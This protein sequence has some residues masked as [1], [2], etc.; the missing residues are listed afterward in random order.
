MHAPPQG[1]LGDGDEGQHLRLAQEAGVRQRS[2]GRCGRGIRRMGGGDRNAGHDRPLIGMQPAKVMTCSATTALGQETRQPPGNARLLDH[3]GRSV[4]AVDEEAFRRGPLPSAPFGVIRSPPRR[5]PAGRRAVRVRA[6]CRAR[7]HSAPGEFGRRAGRGGSAGTGRHDEGIEPT[8]D[9]AGI[10]CD[11]TRCGWRPGV[12]RPLVCSALRWRRHA[13]AG[14]PW[15]GHTVASA[16]LTGNTP[17]PIAR[18]SVGP[19]R[20]L[21]EIWDRKQVHHL[22][23]DRSDWHQRRHRLDAAAS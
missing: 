12:I 15:P 1:G 2:L 3:R 6:R 5:V 9:E 18:A 4:R 10:D 22:L 17:A 11:A 21:G 20:R 19:R 14:S 13:S 8:M 23:R 16:P 7:P